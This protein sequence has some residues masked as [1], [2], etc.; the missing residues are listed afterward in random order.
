ML[1]ID[2]YVIAVMIYSLCVILFKGGMIQHKWNTIKR[3]ER[4]F[5][6]MLLVPYISAVSIGVFLIITK[7]VVL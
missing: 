5:E 2:I 4:I 7:E 6:I 3:N 1:K